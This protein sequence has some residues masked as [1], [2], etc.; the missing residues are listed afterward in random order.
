MF[1]TRAI[2]LRSIK[3]GE[4][5]L[6]VTAFTELFGV[7]TYMVNGVRSTKKTGLKAS[8]YQPAS[9]VD[10][11]VYHNEKNAMHRIRECNRVHVFMHVLSDVVKNS[12]AVFMMELLY[13]L[14]KQ[15]EQNAD[16][17]YFCED[18]IIQLD[19][20]SPKVAANLPLF[21]SLQLSHFFGFKIDDNFSEENTFLDLQEGN[22]ISEPPSHGNFLSAD[23]ATIT[24]EILKIMVPAEL[25][26]LKLNHLK[27]R[28]LLQKYMDYYAL[29]ISEFGQM[30]TLK[31]MQE[32]LSP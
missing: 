30:K 19:S 2:I 5:S 8:L 32:V 9:V 18:V 1:K 29:H 22:F 4:T 25:E 31:V 14:L 7:Q 10:M 11:E 12:I 21:F 6:V 20:A 27:R 28:E 15:P 23:N 26:Q 13:K 16:L 24:S 17:F 3:Y